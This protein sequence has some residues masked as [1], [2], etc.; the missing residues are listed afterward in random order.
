MRV[1]NFGSL[2][3][4]TTYFVSHIV[5]PGETL[6]S[7]R[8]EISVGGKGLNQTVALAKGGAE[9][10][11]AGLIGEDGGFLK[12]F[13]DDM[14]VNTEFV[15]KSECRTGSAMIQVDERG[16]NCIVLY[17]GANQ[18]MTEEYID[19][20]LA[21]F[22]EGDWLVLQNEI[23]LLSYIIGAGSRRGMKIAL[24]PS[25]FNEKIEQCDLRKCEM[26]LVNEVEVG[27]ITGEKTPDRALE[28]LLELYPDIKVVLTAGKKG[29]YY[30]DK[31]GTIFQKA[32]AVKVVDTTGA[33]DTFTGFFL[34]EY[35]KTGDVNT[36]M[37]YGT[38]AAAISVTR[39]GAAESMPS[40]DQVIMYHHK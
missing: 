9:A 1:L 12:Q 11:H 8:V 30:G 24:N 36:A 31:T 7:D 13:L 40:F 33:G 21:D 28:R 4:D 29:A 17:G 32:E 10:Y 35:I 39:K 15:K 22:G 2:N 25:P 20:V 34:S 3:I 37:K 26:L 14:G 5:Q 27:Q 18:Q 16:E 38:A 23:N 6:S 19:N